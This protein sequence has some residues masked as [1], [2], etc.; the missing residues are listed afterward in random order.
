MNRLC[1]LAAVA[2]VPTASSLALGPPVQVILD[3][4]TSAPGIQSSVRVP[5]GTRFVSNIGVRLFDPQPSNTHGIVSIGFIGG[6]DRGISLGHIPSGRSLGRVVRLEPARGTPA[7][8]ASTFFELL[9][10]GVLM[11]VFE[12]PEVQYLEGGADRPFN[13]PA[14]LGEPLFT[15]RVELEDAAAGD[16]FVFDIADAV[17]VNWAGGYGC[18]T[19]APDTYLD[20]GGDAV[21]DGTRMWLG[22]DLDMPLPSPP[23]YYAVD[24]IGG[25]NIPARIIIEGCRAD[26]NGDQQADFFDYLDFAIAFDA[27]APEADFNRD[28]QIDFFDYL[29]FALAFDLGCE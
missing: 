21:P 6:I 2:A 5:A 3:M 7:N 28:G 16:E 4:D 29:D 1:L 19:S 9:T 13:F 14:T 22:T 15:V 8:P 20:C 23:A 12:G 18:F 17:A 24:F 27:D 25:G 26:F 11:P 10:P